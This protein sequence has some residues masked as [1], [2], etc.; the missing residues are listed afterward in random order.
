M[1]SKL[2]LLSLCLLVAACATGGLAVDRETAPHAVPR[3]EMTA[4]ADTARVFPVARAPELPS[5]DRIARKIRTELGEVASAEVRLCVTADGRV[6][7]ARIVRGSSLAE[8]DQALLY[9]M[10]DWQ[11]S[12]MPGSNT[13]HLRSCEIATI[14][15]RLRS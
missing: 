8:F 3:I 1:M 5:A 10:A 6:E 7:S 15:Y 4:V 2:A 12:G 11:F 9:D 13:A 14:S